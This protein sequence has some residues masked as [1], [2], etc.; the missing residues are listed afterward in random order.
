MR[1]VSSVWFDLPM[2]VDDARDPEPASVA[3]IVEVALNGVTTKDVNPRVPRS[4]SEIATDALACIEAG[5]AIVHNHND[6]FPWVDDGVHAAGPYIEAWKPVL[7][8]HPD[9]LLYPTMASG[10]PGIAIERRWAHQVELAR[11][12][13]CQVGLVDP[14]SVSFGLLDDRG[15]PMALDL[16][17]L[18]TFADAR[19]MVERCV[20][21]GLAPSISIFDPSF[22]RVALA[23]HHAGALPVGTLIKLYFGGNIPFG[24][25]P[26]ATSLDAYLAMLEGTGLP[27]LVAVLGGDVVSCG[28]AEA[29]LQRGGHVRVGLEDYAGDRTPSNLEL[30]QEA[31]ELIEASGRRIA[32]PTEA[33]RIL[34]L[35]PPSAEAA[36]TRS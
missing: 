33:R 12:G 29:A 2:Q 31:V 8:A 20:E 28:L 13:V 18:N 35:A 11:A 36:A 34:G 21:L 3:C 26:T 1:L 19:Y 16:V 10:G 22:L 25:P 6:E 17:Y 15:L 32:T 27:W 14:G 7:A 24:L 30:V 5:A 4:P 9:V 23:F